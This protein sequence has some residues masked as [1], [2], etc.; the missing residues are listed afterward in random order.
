MRLPNVYIRFTE[1][2]ERERFLYK[3]F[4]IREDDWKT[5]RQVE[6]LLNRL[7]CGTTSSP[8]Y[9]A[10]KHAETSSTPPRRMDRWKPYYAHTLGIRRIYSR[11]RVGGVY[12]RWLAIQLE[13]NKEGNRLFIWICEYVP[14]EQRLIRGRIPAALAS[15]LL[16]REAERT[17]F[18]VPD[19]ARPSLALLNRLEQLLREAM[20]LDASRFHG[21][22]VY[23]WEQLAFDWASADK[24]QRAEY[25][26]RAQAALQPGNGG[27]YLNLGFHYA[28]AGKKKE[29]LNAYLEGLR[30]EPGDE[31]LLHNLANLYLEMGTRKKALVAVNEAILSNP[32]LP[33][34]YQ[35]KGNLHLAWNEPEAALQCYRQALSLCED[36]W[37]R[38]ADELNQAIQALIQTEKER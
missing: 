25:C 38:L 19:D 29:A 32:S 11:W 26:L 33:S 4:G 16:L 3:I 23:L 24:L 14:N 6:P 10:Y 15:E 30:A 7:A 28:S 27:P 13:D 17:R 31:F 37:E 36:G 8:Y 35:L 1:K 2:E 5:R 20:R 9:R 22:R 18:N 12:G 34:I 21:D